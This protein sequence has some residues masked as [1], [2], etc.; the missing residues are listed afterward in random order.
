MPRDLP[1]T[2]RLA[3]RGTPVRIMVVGPRIGGPALSERKRSRLLQAF[4]KRLPGIDFDIVDEGRGALPAAQGFESMRDEIATVKPDLVLWQVGTSDALNHS[5]TEALGRTLVQ[6]A[7]WL[8]AQSI[9]LIVVDPPFVPNV[10]HE[11]LY[12]RI[13]G[14]IDQVSTDSNINLVR[15]YA[16]TQ[17]LD[18]ER[19]KARG[20]DAAPPV[21]C[22]PDLV[23]EA[24]Y[25][26][27]MR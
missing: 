16:A 24:V 22:L 17:H 21:N 19:R 26:S 25:R 12:A 1:R 10:G 23:A 18:Q 15:R 6:A 20:S 2:T 5:D 13:V 8:R 27:V 9:D 3:D 14:K 7:E 11:K 4:E